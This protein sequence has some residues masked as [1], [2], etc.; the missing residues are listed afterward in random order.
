MPEE[1]GP[2]VFVLHLFYLLEALFSLIDGIFS[3]VFTDYLCILLESINYF[4]S[5]KYAARPRK[6]VTKIKVR[7]YGT[8][9]KMS[10]IFMWGFGRSTSNPLNN[11]HLSKILL[12]ASF[13]HFLYS[14]YPPQNFILFLT[15]SLFFSSISPLLFFYYNICYYLICPEFPFVDQK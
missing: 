6:R 5:F 1:F 14:T 12:Y 8:K 15:H 11:D 2:R 4:Y 7:L 9:H 3:F 10:L 13:L